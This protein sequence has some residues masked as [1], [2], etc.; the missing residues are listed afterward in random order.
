M[1]KIDQILNIW[2]VFIYTIYYVPT[3]RINLAVFS[4]VIADG[5][6]MIYCVHSEIQ[7]VDLIVAALK[8]FALKVF[9]LNSVE[10][11]F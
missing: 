9:I 1:I 3:W 2:L 11:P 7:C 4:F 5:V 6:I 8:R 10:H